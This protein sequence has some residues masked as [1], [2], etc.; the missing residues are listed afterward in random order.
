MTEY[1]NLFESGVLRT[2][3]SVKTKYLKRRVVTL[4]IISISIVDAGFT[5]VMCSACGALLRS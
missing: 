2:A 3:T 5:A 1:I 4:R